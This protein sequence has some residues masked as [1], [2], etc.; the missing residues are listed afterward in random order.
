MSMK[1]LLVAAASALTV[2]P[3]LAMSNSQIVKHTGGPIPYGQ[4]VSMDKSGYNARSHKRHRSS[5][6]DTAVAANSSTSAT[7]AAPDQTSA[8]PAPSPTPDLAAPNPADAAGPAATPLP[9]APSAT[10]PAPNTSTTPPAPA[11]SPQ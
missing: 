10:T 11:G 6:T 5:T 9:P 3:A 2:S 7:A 4:L 1:L 8:A